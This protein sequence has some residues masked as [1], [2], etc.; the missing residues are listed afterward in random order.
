MAGHLSCLLNLIC[1]LF[2]K[3]RVLYTDW[4][5]EIEP[6]KVLIRSRDLTREEPDL[7]SRKSF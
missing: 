6:V 4:K 5:Q 2:P 1:A 7:K 3:F